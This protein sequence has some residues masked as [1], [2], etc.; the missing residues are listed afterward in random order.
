M[1]YLLAPSLSLL[2]HVHTHND[3]FGWT[4]WEKVGISIMIPHFQIFQSYY[5]RTS[6]L[7]YI[8]KNATLKLKKF[9][10]NQ[11][12]YNKQPTQVVLFVLIKCFIIVFL[13]FYSGII[14]YSKMHS[15]NVQFNVLINDNVLIGHSCNQ[16]PHQDIEPFCNPRMFLHIPY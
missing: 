12:L 5:F 3:F 2:T 4:I 8:T 1:K 14:M 10:M 16:Y 7:F 15:L 9:V 6:I 13:M 11:L